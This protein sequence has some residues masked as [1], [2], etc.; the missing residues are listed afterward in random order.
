MHSKRLFFSKNIIH[1]RS[2]QQGF[3]LIETIVGIVLLSIVFSIFTT[4]I[5]P[6][7][8]QSAEQVHQIRA[9]ELG[10]SIINEILGKA[11]DENSDM[12]G[13]LYRCGDDIDND[14]EILAANGEREC[15]PGLGNEESNNRELSD[16]VDDYSYIGF[17]A[18]EDSLGNGLGN[19][20]TGF[21]VNV[22]VIN[23]SNYDGSADTNNST[24]KLITVTIKTP[25][26]FDF[27]F[28]AYKANF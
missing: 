8:N 20:Y 7:A 5:Y 27:V 6:L 24:A 17:R 15:S 11:F 10:Q 16:D 22:Q 3:T 23:D 2:L 9:A 4:L 1:N 13:G 28:S 18:V 12:S 21:Q 14:G 26:K 19:I 25:Q